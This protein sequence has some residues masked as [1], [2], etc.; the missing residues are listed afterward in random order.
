[1]LLPPPAP[2]VRA[3]RS[4]QPRVALQPLRGLRSTRCYIP[5]PAPR[6][7]PPGGHRRPRNTGNGPGLAIRS[8]SEFRFTP[9]P[10]K[11]PRRPF[12]L[13]RTNCASG[14]RNRVPFRCPVLGASA[15]ARTSA[16]FLLAAVAYPVAAGRPRGDDSAVEAKRA[17]EV[18]KMLTK[19]AT[20][21]LDDPELSLEDV[22]RYFEKTYDVSFEVN[23]QAFKDEM[24]RERPGQAH[25]EAP[26][27]AEECVTRH[28]PAPR[29]GS[30]PLAFGNDLHRPRRCG[31]DYHSL[32][33]FAIA[34]AHWGF[35]NQCTDCFNRLRKE[36]V[37][38]WAPGDCRRDGD[39]RRAGRSRQGQ[40]QNPR[41]GDHARRVGGHGGADPREH[42][43]PRRWSHWTMCCALPSRE[44]AGGLPQ[45]GRKRRIAESHQRRPGSP[46]RIPAAS[47]N[48]RI[49]KERDEEIL[50]LQAKL[51]RL[52]KPEPEMHKE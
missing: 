34:L 39:Q 43:R 27:K 38:G 15:M 42:G 36:G 51:R 52:G 2:R 5:P 17:E 25:R 48:E 40:R 50:R 18:R 41:D 37:A 21:T 23:E 45:G 14:R 29:P 11:R 20:L 13:R 10:T 9:A 24:L 26:R 22:L 8:G 12:S 28:G 32:R 44:D 33:W 31:G 49:I 35:A 47:G 6:A 46:A 16:L 30:D 3:C 4:A 7:M 1:M 19:T